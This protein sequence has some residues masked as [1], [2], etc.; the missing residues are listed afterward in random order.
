MPA[1]RDGDRAA[2]RIRIAVGAENQY[3]VV[4]EG[5]SGRDYPPGSGI[6]GICGTWGTC[7]LSGGGDTVS[8]TVLVL[9]LVLTDVLGSV[10]VVDGVVVSALVVGVVVSVTV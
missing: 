2:G 5:V 10:V 3:G 9:V 7:G 8:V 6:C 1:Q 4:G